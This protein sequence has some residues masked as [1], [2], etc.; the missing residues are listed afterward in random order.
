MSLARYRWIPAEDL[1]FLSAGELAAYQA[2]RRRFDLEVKEHLTHIW[3]HGWL[4]V[5]PTGKRPLPYHVQSPALA[6]AS[7]AVSLLEWLFGPVRGR[8]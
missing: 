7:G 2:E 8:R 1:P 3:R 4:D 5:A 6:I